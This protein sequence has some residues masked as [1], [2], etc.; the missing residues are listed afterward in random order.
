MLLLIQFTAHSCELR[1]EQILVY[2]LV[3]YLPGFSL[4][5]VSMNVF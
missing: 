3:E 5:A 1:A 2:E 4:F